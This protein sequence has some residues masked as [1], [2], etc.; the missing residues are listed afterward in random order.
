MMLKSRVLKFSSFV[1]VTSVLLTFSCKEDEPSRLTLQ[2]TADL[3]EEAI[4]DAYFQDMDD[5]AGVAIGAPT[6][7][8]YSSGRTSGSVVIEDHRFDCEGIVVTVAPDAASTPEVPKGVLTVDFG[9]SGCTDLKGNVRTGKL[10]FTYH[11]K[12]FMPGSTIVTTPDNYVINGVK[13][14]GIR[15]LTNLQNSTSDAPRFNAVLSDGKAS[16]SDETSATRESSITWQWNRTQNPLNDNLEVE[17][18]SSA[19]GT[20]R[21]G[22]TYEIILLEPLVYKRHCGIAVSGIKKYTIDGEKEITIDYGDGE[23]DRAFTVTING[24]TREIAL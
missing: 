5:I 7:P 15:T 22:R 9:T 14:E 2:D 12:R 6:E 10:I 11:G 13:L 18:T 16:F 20:S 3:T 23:C 8:Q 19:S 4:T 1:L 24:V 17:S 21:G